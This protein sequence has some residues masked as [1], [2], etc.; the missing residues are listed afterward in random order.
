MKSSRLVAINGI[1][2]GLAA[3]LL[4]LGTHATTI[5]QETVDV[6]VTIN[7]VLALAATNNVAGTSSSYD[8]TNN[9]YSGSIYARTAADDFGTTTYEVTCN[10]LTYTESGTTYPGCEN[11]WKVT[12]ESDTN[13]N[14]YA[15][16]VGGASNAHKI[17]SNKANGHDGSNSNWLMK[18]VPVSNGGGALAAYTATGINYADF[19]TIPIS[20]STNKTVVTGNT[21]TGP[22]NGAYTY[23]GTQ[24]FNA[25]YSVSAGSSTPA[26]TYT[27]SIT[28]TLSVNAAS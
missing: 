12:A 27:G 11:G 19:E 4:P 15:T 24:S 2:L 18:I 26:D 25:V 7:G 23:I 22:V 6:S 1:L 3:T 14:S 13:N 10:Y 28:Y 16:M 5:A 21:F 20:T 17:L 9:I 8:E